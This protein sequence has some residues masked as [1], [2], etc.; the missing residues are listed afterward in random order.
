VAVA[1]FADFAA[2]R[3][4]VAHPLHQAYARDHASKVIGSESLCSTNGRFRARNSGP[5]SKSAKRPAQKQLNC[6]RCSDASPCFA[7][8]CRRKQERPDAASKQ[9]CSY[10]A[11]LR[12]C[13]TPSSMSSRSNG[14]G[15]AVMP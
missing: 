10:R 3:R 12:T 6:D 2:A 13:S 15:R 7:S 11:R 4:Y 8:R 1:D 9:K 5:P 14:F